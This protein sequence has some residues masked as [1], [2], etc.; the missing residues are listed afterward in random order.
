MYV[1]KFS[2]KKISNIQCRSLGQSQ[3]Q[4]LKLIGKSSTMKFH[5]LEAA[6]AVRQEMNDGNEMIA[7]IET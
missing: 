7:V 4:G 2:K 6:A 3:R 1:I 5:V